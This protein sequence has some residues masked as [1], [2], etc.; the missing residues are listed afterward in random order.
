M[1]DQYQYVILFF[2]I[3]TA[4]TLANLTSTAINNKEVETVTAISHKNQVITI[5]NKK[6]DTAEKD[7]QLKNG[8]PEADINKVKH[9]TKEQKEINIIIKETEDAIQM[10]RS[11]DEYGT[12]LSMQ[13]G[14]WRRSLEEF[15]S[16]VAR[17]SVKKYCD[18]Y[19]KYVLTGEYIAED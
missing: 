8:Q 19:E 11:T 12:E 13:C 17:Y 2:V 3:F 18:G 6:P 4:V 15:E 5:A 7:G 14:Q 1:K 9:I 10:K 16:D